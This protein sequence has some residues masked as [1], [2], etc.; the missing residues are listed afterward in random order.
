MFQKFKW[1]TKTKTPKHT[2]RCDDRGL[3]FYSNA[4]KPLK[5]AYPLGTQG[6]IPLLL[7]FHLLVLLRMVVDFSPGTREKKEKYKI[8]R[9][10]RCV[11]RVIL[12]TVKLLIQTNIILKFRPYVKENTNY[13][14]CDEINRT[15]FEGSSEQGAE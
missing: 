6:E 12:K 14:R 9:P 5:T 10:F 4:R 7:S 11:K 3:L 1:N 15:E 2:Q 8:R 13:L